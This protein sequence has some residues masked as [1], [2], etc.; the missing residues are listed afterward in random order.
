MHCKLYIYYIYDAPLSL[1]VKKQNRF[2]V[3]RA[4]EGEPHASGGRGGGG[5][6]GGGGQRTRKK[7][8]GKNAR[9]RLYRFVVRGLLIAARGQSLTFQVIFLF[10]VFCFFDV[11]AVLCKIYRLECICF[12]VGREICDTRLGKSG[13]GSWGSV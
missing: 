7:L 2:A 3:A 9:F 1:E 5:G 6:G 4:N 13:R 12:D 11:I 8:G 10:F